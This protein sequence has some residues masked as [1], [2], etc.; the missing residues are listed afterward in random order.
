M[1]TPIIV[2]V[3]SKYQIAVP[4]N[5]RRQLNIQKSDQLLVEVQGGTVVLIP[6]PKEYTQ[7]L[8]GLHKEIWENKDAQEYL[9]GERETWQPSEK[10]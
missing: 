3:S 4:A 9:T 2:K 8:S 6:K 7:H 5:I 10:N 1:T